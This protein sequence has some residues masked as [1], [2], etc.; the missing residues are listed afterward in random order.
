MAKICLVPPERTGPGFDHL[1]EDFETLA[2]SAAE[3]GGQ[4]GATDDPSDADILLFVGS[5]H[6]FHA[7]VR[8][9]PLAMGA[10][11][12]VLLYDS[13]DHVIP[14]LPGIY[15]SIEARYYDPRRVRSGFYL[16][17]IGSSWVGPVGRPSQARFLFS[18]TGAFDNSGLRRRLARLD[19]PAGLLRDTSS[20]PGRGYGQSAQ[21]Y[22]EYQR[23]YVQSLS[24]SCFVLC[25]RGVGCGTVRLFETMRAARVPV[26]ISD[27]WVPTPGPD[28]DACSLRVRESE[29]DALPA[30]LEDSR[31]R[32]DQ[33]GEAA[34]EAWRRW[35][36]AE[37]AFQ[38]MAGW[39]AEI[40][41]SLPRVNRVDEWLVRA[42]LFR[43]WFLRWQH[44]PRLK[45]AL[46]MLLI[47]KQPASAR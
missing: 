9:H 34:Y 25:P 2:R 16:R 7:D 31:G 8:K 19:H 12:R 28:W 10:S 15:P 20:E 37:R 6:P 1:V 38:T 17:G 14:F 32:A 40:V 4:H 39:C 36:S 5:R 26:V 29:I 41:E 30:L 18:F 24:E 27:A 42:Q 46:V 23:R 22:G 33:M 11:R 21:V 43:P 44:L 13:A 47:R 45:R 3:S 35:F